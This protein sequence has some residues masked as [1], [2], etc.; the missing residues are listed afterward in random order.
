MILWPSK[1]QC[2]N[3]GITSGKWA[4]SS[5]SIWRLQSV[6][7]TKQNTAIISAEQELKGLKTQKESLTPFL[8]KRKIIKIDKKIKLLEKDIERLNKTK[9]FTFEIMLEA[10][11]GSEYSIRHPDIT[12]ILSLAALVPPSTAEVERSF[13]LMKLISTRL[14]I[15]SCQ[16]TRV[17][18]CVFASSIES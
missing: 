6:R 1:Q 9:K 10:W 12:H 4:S 5:S 14:R 11:I 15:Y 7:K 8:S 13:S 16:R 17:T 18:S 3:S 2:R